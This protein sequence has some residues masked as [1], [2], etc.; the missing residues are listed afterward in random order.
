MPVLRI[1]PQ[2]KGE[3][4]PQQLQHLPT[5]ILKQ[6]PI[7]SK[8][9]INNIRKKNNTKKLYLRVFN[10]LLAAMNNAA[11]MRLNVWFFAWLSLIGSKFLINNY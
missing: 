6:I 4:A 5:Q 1:S 11:V 10:L 3:S 2:I 9:F 7:R 8:N